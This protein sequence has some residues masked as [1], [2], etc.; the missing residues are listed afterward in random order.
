M[1]QKEV[2]QSIAREVTTALFDNF[3][4][5]VLAGRAAITE[6]L[7]RPETEK[8]VREAIEGN[9]NRIV[10]INKYPYWKREDVTKADEQFIYR[11]VLAQLQPL[12]IE[13]LRQLL[14]DAAGQHEAGY[15]YQL[16]AFQKDV[17]DLIN[18]EDIS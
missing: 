12:M 2:L 3:L 6:F 13:Q 16:T 15:F 8:A 9:W 18:R 17:Y 4:P 14:V 1:I 5:D 10:D 7:D 11:K